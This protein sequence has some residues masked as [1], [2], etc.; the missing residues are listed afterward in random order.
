MAQQAMNKKTPPRRETLD[1]W[2]HTRAAAVTTPVARG[3]AALNVHPNTMTL[4]GFALNVG[5]A[6]VI[7][8][9]YPQWGGLAMLLASSTDA[10]DGALARLTG[11]LS[12]FGAFLDSTLDRLSEGAALLGLLSWLLAEGHDVD[13][14]LVFLTLLGSV[15]VSYTRAR[16]E[17]LGLTCKVG[18]LTR[19]MRVVILGLG[20]LT[21]WLRPTLIL[22][23]VLIWLTV[24]QRILHVYR[25]AQRA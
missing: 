5:A 17:G 13:V 3:L 22:L 9:G 23:V 24:V 20:L 14:Y 25:Q 16:A 6:L 15:M 12:H 7:A 10:L 21:L 19:P 18:L 4:I 2:L 8:S 1:D 11:K